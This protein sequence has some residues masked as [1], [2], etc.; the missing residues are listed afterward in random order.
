[1]AFCH[2]VVG[3]VMGAH[4]VNVPE[5]NGDANITMTVSGSPAYTVIAFSYLLIIIYALTLAP[6]CWI[7]AAEVWSLETRA[8]GMGISAIGNWLVGLSI[9]STPVPMLTRSSSTLLLVSSYPLPSRTSST[10]SSCFSEPSVFLARSSSSSP[11]RR[12]AERLSK[13]LRYSSVT[14]VLVPGRQGKD[15]SVWNTMLMM[16]PI[17]RPRRQASPTQ[18]RRRS[19]DHVS[20]ICCISI[21]SS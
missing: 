11:T 17:L 16:S 4:G 5:V 10:V 15:P 8:T 2:F 12:P 18:R 1:M 14:R 7:Y 13:R 19:E 6:V 21:D 3:G 20:S 9:C